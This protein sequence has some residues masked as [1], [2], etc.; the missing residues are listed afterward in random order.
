MAISGREQLRGGSCALVTVKNTLGWLL[1]GSLHGE[2][3]NLSSVY[4][5]QLLTM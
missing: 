1:S 3:L 4:E 2:R 5:N